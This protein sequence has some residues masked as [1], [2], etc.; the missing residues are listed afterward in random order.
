MRGWKTL[1][2]VVAGTALAATV[3]ADDRPPKHG[4][5]GITPKVDPKID[6]KVD[7]KPVTGKLTVGIT[8]DSVVL[9]GKAFAL[10]FDQK[11][12]IA[13]LGKPTR[14]TRLTST[15]LTWDELGVVAFVKPGGTKVVAV[16]IALDR[17]TLSFW[18]KKPF[19]GAV[20][21]DG[22]EVTAAATVEGINKA[23]KG[24]PFDK[25]ASDPNG[26]VADG[27]AAAVYLRRGAGGKFVEL[28]ID[29]KDD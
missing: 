13:I 20:M 19:V 28:L 3:A 14:E 11:D 22:A 8:G 5:V 2:V 1:G 17:D 12:L 23:K 6:P 26:W 10:P 7:P 16:S 21:V 25:D 4:T 27:K 18:P 15:L 24:R 9:N 29:A